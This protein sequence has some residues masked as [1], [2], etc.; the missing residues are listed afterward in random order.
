MTLYDC[1]YSLDKVYL[2]D[3]RE[4]YELEETGI[5]APNAVNIPRKCTHNLPYGTL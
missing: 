3:V 5:I 2:I 4:P 1:A